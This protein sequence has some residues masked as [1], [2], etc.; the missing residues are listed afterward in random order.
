MLNLN[1][2]TTLV[3]LAAGHNVMGLAFPSIVD[4]AAPITLG[5]AATFGVVA[6][7]TVTNTGATVV[8]GNIA[9]CPGTAVTMFP[10]GV[11]VGSINVGSSALGCE[12]EAACRA[13]YVAGRI[14]TV[15]EILPSADLVGLTLTPGV[16]GFP[17]SSA[18]NSGVLTLSGVGQFVFDI[19]TTFSTAANSAIVLTNGATAN[20]VYFLV[21]S[22]VSSLGTNS[23]FNGNIIALTA[24][25]LNANVTNHGTICALNA[26]V[27]L[28]DDH[29]TFA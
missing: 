5:I 11:V 8:T 25:A 14:L 26:A 19:T 9:V 23:S 1:Q 27:T 13:A 10:P 6:N 7:T 15:T 22:S 28:S 21:G 17:T 16:Y 29:L 4:R 24:V 20:N 2:L 12:A 18:T 3:I